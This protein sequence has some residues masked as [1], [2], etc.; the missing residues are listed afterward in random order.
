MSLDCSARVRSRAAIRKGNGMKG[1][2]FVGRVLI[3][4]LAQAAPAMAAPT[5]IRL[6]YSDCATCHLSPQGGGLLTTYGKGIDVAQSIMAREFQPKDAEHRRLLYDMRFLLGSQVADGLAKNTSVT[7]TT[8]QM[9]LRSSIRV[10][11]Q[12][13]FVGTFALVGPTLIASQPAVG[14][15]TVVVP[16][17]LWEFRPKNGLSLYMGRDELPTGVGLPDPQAYLRR[18]TD[19]G[20][21]VYPTQ[22]KVFLWNN[23]FQVTPYAFGPGGDEDQ[24]L[25]QWGAGGLA[26]VDVW[27][28]KAIIGVSGLDSRSP[29]F[30]R[31]SVGAY[32]RLGFGKWGILAEH[33]LTGRSTADATAK[34][35]QYVDGHTQVFYAPWEWFVTSLGAEEVATH[36]ATVGH[37]YRLAPGVQIRVSEYLTTVF[38]IRDVFSGL[39]AGRTRTF[40][41]GLA[42][43]TVN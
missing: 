38:T 10:N 29:A 5:M 14:A 23:R 15:T 34:T 43:K 27:K 35:T 4:V 22:V 2:T 7:S 40:S 37:A 19:L 24:R 42:I 20:T 18:S 12:H 31:R 21:T 11:D 1:T 26:G 33:E 39:A 16:K 3:L 9:Q 17:A 36:G 8:L 30:N 28:H 6:G 13:R 25:R 32:A 41:F